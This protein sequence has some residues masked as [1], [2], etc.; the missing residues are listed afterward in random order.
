MQGGERRTKGMKNKFPENSSS[1][2]SVVLVIVNQ[3]IKNLQYLK[4]L[5][6]I[7]LN[8]LSLHSNYFFNNQEVKNITVV[9]G[10]LFSFIIIC[11]CCPSLKGQTILID[12]I[13][14]TPFGKVYVYTSG[15]VSPQNLII[16]ISGDGGWKHGVPEFAKEFSRMNSVVVGVDILRYYKHL[17]KKKTDCYM[18]SPDFV[19]LATT[20]EHKYSFPGYIPPVVMGYSS[21]ATLV[22]GILAQARPGSFIG[23]ISL[24]FCPDIE[25]PEML[26]QINGLTVKGIEKGKGYIFL[27][28]AR[29]GNPWVVLHGE[30]D[31]ICD[32][33]STNDFVHKT[34][35]S[36][37]IALHEVGHDFSKWSDFMPQWKAAYKEMI[38]GFNSY[39]SA[40]NQIPRLKN[41]PH[42][43]TSGNN[44]I[45]NNLI[46]VLFS[47]DG[48]WYGFEQAIANRFANLGIPTIGIDTKK[49]FWTRKSPETT[50][51]D[52]ADLLNSYSKE[53]NKSQFILV[54]YSQGAEIIPFVLNRL[55]DELKIKVTSTVMLS[56]EESTDFEIH[57]TNMLGLGNKQNTYDV[58]AEIKRIKDT[59]Q[60]VIFGEL[61]K[62]HVPDLLKG[63][64]V[65]IVRIPGDHHYKSNSE[66]I[67]QTMR[68]KMAF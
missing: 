64:Q 55:P 58:I 53:W 27:P 15:A 2:V 5:F 33:Q 14:V 4:D 29:L 35:D 18:V 11:C 49:Y 25:L 50:A 24:G 9:R 54:G 20:I 1:N 67:V 19:E 39:I 57:I 66:L 16:M 3:I 62:T 37:L 45:Y 68:D 63:T 7:F 32:F 31:K 43:I 8:Y 41:I 23:G 6:N 17:R 36:K 26:C 21:G 59:R 51:T 44:G 42:V 65:G 48:G 38:K 47:G 40:D 61:E 12:S 13:I 56:P 22:Y 30:K 10:F 60:I 28:D 46:S 34:A 52:I